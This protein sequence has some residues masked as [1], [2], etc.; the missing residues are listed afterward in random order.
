MPHVTKLLTLMGPVERNQ[1]ADTLE[2]EALYRLDLAQRVV[3]T[4]QAEDRLPTG[5]SGEDVAEAVVHWL[6]NGGAYGIE[7]TQNDLRTTRVLP[8][9]GC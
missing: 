6:F 3:D 5:M 2:A 8:G 9:E 7:E 1:S 4:A